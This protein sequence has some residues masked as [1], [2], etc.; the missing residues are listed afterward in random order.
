[1]SAWTWAAASSRGTSHDKTGA[2][3]QDAFSCWSPAALAP[4]VALISDGAG[5]AARGGEGASLVCR[6]LMTQA[7]RHFSTSVE[8]PSDE[9][10]ATWF[11]TTRDLLAAV[12]LRHSQALKDFA[13]TSV[14]VF[15]TGSRT[16]IAHVGDGCAVLREADSGRWIAPSWPQHGEY[17]AT[18]YF[19]TDADVL[20]LRITR[21]ESGVSA[22][23]VFSDG[24]ERLALD[25]STQVPSQKFFDKISAPIGVSNCKGRDASLSRS[26]KA[27]LG[28]SAV[29]N[30]TDDDKSL[31]VAVLK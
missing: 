7:R 24:I 12:A 27:Y 3:I 1:M 18:T 13:S 19:V 23:A 11:D 8:L 29:N 6:T 5:T 16:V 10:I 4:I 31:V 15:S 14:S 22:F 26:L 9:D 20:Q 25:F 17:A 30:R 28:S 2:R 21:I